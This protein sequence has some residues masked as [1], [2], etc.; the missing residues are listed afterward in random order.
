MLIF[1]ILL[2]LFYLSY[3][4]P[5]N[6]LISIHG[7]R[8]TMEF[9]S[10]RRRMNNGGEA[11]GDFLDAWTRRKRGFTWCL[12]VDELRIKLTDAMG[13]RERA[14]FGLK[15]KKCV[16]G[17]HCCRSSAVYYIAGGEW[18]RF[19]LFEG[20]VRNRK[21]L[22]YECKGKKKKESKFRRRCRCYQIAI[23]SVFKILHISAAYP[24]INLYLKAGMRIITVWI[25]QASLKV[26]FSS[27]DIILQFRSGIYW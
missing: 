20:I 24:Y 16:S 8:L 17:L 12:D 27:Y 9:A 4:G 23:R 22:D 21:F 3:S 1:N 26:Q 2:P 18:S 11:G 7:P 15:M 6:P 19:S 10:S 25:C 14:E 13:T 5:A